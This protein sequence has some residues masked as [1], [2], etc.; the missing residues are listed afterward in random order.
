MTFNPAIWRPTAMVLSAI[1]LIAVGPAAAS[2]EPWHAA[3]H[4]GLALAFGLWA[5]RMRHGP[6]RSD[7]EDRLEALEAEVS[8]LR[9]EL[10]EA[11]DRLDFAERLLAQGSEARRL[12]PER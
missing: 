1:N 4:A 12:G 11:Q 10:T 6:G 9:G 2:T 7:R 3:G 5:Q 8:S